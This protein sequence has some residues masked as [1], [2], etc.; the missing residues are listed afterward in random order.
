[1]E[2]VEV[3]SS[4]TTFQLKPKHIPGMSGDCPKGKP[5]DAIAYVGEGAFFL[6]GTQFSEKKFPL[7]EEL[8]AKGL[9]EDD[10]AAICKSLRDGKGKT[11]WGGGFSKAI[12]QA[13]KDH[14]EKIDCVAVYAEYGMG[15]KAIV[16]L[17]KDVA[18]SG[19]AVAY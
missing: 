18:D 1:M 13:Q 4:G 5:D 6:T 9:S 19:R 12:A 15:Q 3:E 11:G 10:W 14:I 8:K 16:V 7:S 2:K 17:T